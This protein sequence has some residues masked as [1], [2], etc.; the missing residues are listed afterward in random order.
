MNFLCRS[1]LVLAILNSSSLSL[2]RIYRSLDQLSNY[3]AILVLLLD[4]SGM[5]WIFYMCFVHPSH[6]Q[7][8]KALWCCP[9]LNI[10]ATF[11]VLPNSRGC[12]RC[13]ILFSIFL[14]SFRS[15]L[16]WTRFL[17]LWLFAFEGSPTFSCCSRGKRSCR[18]SRISR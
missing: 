10:F 17:E 9:H 3:Y 5:F 14:R 13:Y 8:R 15:L 1:F 11:P 18:S 7:N 12:P 6:N 4:L 2:L 16:S